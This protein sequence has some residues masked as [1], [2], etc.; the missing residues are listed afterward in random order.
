[1]KKK[2]FSV[3]VLAIA[4]A[5]MLTSNLFA[6]NISSITLMLFAGLVSISL[7]LMKGGKQA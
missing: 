7:Y 1:M 2:P 5:V 4:A 6:L 3:A